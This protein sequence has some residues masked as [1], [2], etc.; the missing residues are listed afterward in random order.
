MGDFGERLLQDAR[1][2]GIHKLDKLTSVYQ[3]AIFALYGALVS[4]QSGDKEMPDMTVE[5]HRNIYYW[6]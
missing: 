1:I 5:G 4:E 3:L 2:Y 6:R